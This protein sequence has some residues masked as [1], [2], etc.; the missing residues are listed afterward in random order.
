LPDRTVLTHTPHAVEGCR[1]ERTPDHDHDPRP[2]HLWL[3]HAHRDRG[4]R[5]RVVPRDLAALIERMEAATNDARRVLREMHEAQRDFKSFRQMIGTEVENQ[6]RR[7]ASVGDVYIEKMVGVREEIDRAFE[8]LTMQAARHVLDS[9]D[10]KVDELIR[11]A[12]KEL[13]ADLTSQR[14]N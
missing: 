3:R 5:D 6:R 2:V 4:D 11:A 9:M 7:I 10:E 14:D 12:G 13:A 8:G 1:T